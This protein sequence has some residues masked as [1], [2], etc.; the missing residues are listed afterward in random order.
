[1]LLAEFSER[2]EKVVC[3][4]DVRHTGGLAPRYHK[5]AAATK[6]VCSSYLHHFNLFIVAVVVV[7]VKKK[8]PKGENKI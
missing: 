1:M 8:K 4:C 3:G 2:I 6:L 7:V 5:S